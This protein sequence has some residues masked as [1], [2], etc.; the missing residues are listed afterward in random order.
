MR[1]WGRFAWAYAVLAAACWALIWPRRPPLTHP[2]PPLALGASWA[3][4]P[5]LNSLVVGLAFGLLLVG[6]TRVSVHR[7]GW[8][9][10]L[11]H[12]LAPFARS[13]TPGAVLVL[14][15]LSGLGEELLFRGL[16]QPWMGWV[17][18]AVLFGLVHQ[19][20]GPSRWVWASWACVVGLA[21]GA[22][23]EFSGSLLGPIVAH[24]FVNGLN[25]RFLRRHDPGPLSPPATVARRAR[26]GT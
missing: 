6:F 2:D 9:R 11:H 19:V 15:L 16:L 22:I 24:A 4:S 20:P 3:G 8:A 1:R 18:Q 23:F 14:A 12:D 10:R 5:H 25:L 26:A 7:F 13:L 21:L 17:P